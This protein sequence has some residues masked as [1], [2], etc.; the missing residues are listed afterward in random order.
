MAFSFCSFGEIGK[1]I[2]VK[3]TVSIQSSEGDNTPLLK[4]QLINDG[5]EITTINNSLV[6]IGIGKELQ[7]KVKIDENSSLVIYQNNYEI[8][9]VEIKLNRGSALIKKVINSFYSKKLKE[10]PFSLFIKT[11]YAAMG[12]RGTEFFSYVDDQDK[13]SLDVNEGDVLV[14]SKNSSE[15]FH[16]KE[17][18]GTVSNEKNLLISP[19]AF[20]WRGLINWNLD[21]NQGPVNQ[22]KILFKKISESFEKYQKETEFKW[23]QYEIKN[24]GKFEQMQEKNQKILDQLRKKMNRQ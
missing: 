20:E 14:L 4:D 19:R 23:Q 9:E 13:V 3:G 18:E 1:A 17:G 12:V 21:P 22:S 8:P 15:G 24:K 5:D 7:S 6:I 10:R 16:V 2:Y 11:K